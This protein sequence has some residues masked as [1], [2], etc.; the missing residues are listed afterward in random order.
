MARTCLSVI[1][2]TVTPVEVNRIYNSASKNISVL[3][4]GAIL[5]TVALENFGIVDNKWC[6]DQV[7]LQNVTD[8]M[9]ICGYIL[10]ECETGKMIDYQIPA[11]GLS[12]LEDGTI[13]IDLSCW[14]VHDGCPPTSQSDLDPFLELLCDPCRACTAIE[15][16]ILQVAM[17]QRVVSWSFAGKSVTLKQPNTQNLYKLLCLYQGKCQSQRARECGEYYIP[18]RA[19]TFTPDC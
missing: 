13:C 14:E 17:Q 5:E 10:H 1:A 3:P 12:C 19:S 8:I 16:L 4:S 11:E 9:E 2:E 18:R 7:C 6:A 15:A